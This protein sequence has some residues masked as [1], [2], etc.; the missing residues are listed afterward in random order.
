MRKSFTTISLA[1]VAALSLSACASTADLDELRNEINRLESD[2][3]SLNN[4][5]D[6]ME[7][8]FDDIVDLIEGSRM[9]EWGMFSC[10]GFGWGR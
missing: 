5:I 9:N 1:A 3:R 10:R 8:C 6:D 4:E 7:D 2:I